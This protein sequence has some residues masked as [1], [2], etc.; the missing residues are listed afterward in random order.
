M[1]CCLWW[2]GHFDGF[3]LISASQQDSRSQQVINICL[4][5]GG[6]HYQHSAAWPND[7][8]SYRRR[9]VL[10]WCA[11]TTIHSHSKIDLLFWCN[12]GDTNQRGC[13][14]LQWNLRKKIQY[15]L[16]IEGKSEEYLHLHGRGRKVFLYFV[17]ISE[18][19]PIRC[20]WPHTC[21]KAMELQMG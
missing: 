3:D 13:K 16:Q 14:F 5:S 20:P 4:G 17:L 10:F 18:V 15:S 19:M 9:S 8:A 6:R 2:W 12:R 7:L 11:H 1:L 21:M